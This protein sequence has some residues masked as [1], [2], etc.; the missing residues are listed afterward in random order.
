VQYLPVQ[1]YED[2]FDD[3]SMTA[4]LKYS[5]TDDAMMYLS[6]SEAF[7]GG[8]WNSHFNTCQILEPC[9]T[10]L[11]LTGPD[12]AN[13]VAASE[14]FATG[15]H[16]FGP[17]EA[18]TWELGFKLDLADN[19]LRLN[20]AI[21]TTDYDEL[22][23]TYRSG[24]APYLANAGKA[25][26]DGY[27]LEMTWLPSNNWTVTAGVGGLDSNIDELRTLS[28]VQIGDLEGNKLPFA[29]DLKYNV[30]IGY[31]TVLG[32]GW[33]IAPRIDFV[34]SDHVYWDANNTEEISVNSDYS[35]I[36]AA[37][38][39]GPERGPWQLRAAVTN[40]T[41]EIYSTGGN[42][43][44]TTGSGYAE[45]AYARPRQYFLSFEYDFGAN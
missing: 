41:D 19:T 40:A 8:G 42:S 10:D 24:V 16:S 27:E 7:K 45:I 14:A 21:F 28:I 32:N 35:I 3:F 5:F 38:A 31:D 30:G 4:S 36:N 29:P 25:S 13:A 33:A 18:A 22:Q 39:F 9:A 34:H 43:S 17:E 44:L 15:I 26:I 11:G 23:F 2:T 37:V 20:G 12:Y 1:K 6:Y